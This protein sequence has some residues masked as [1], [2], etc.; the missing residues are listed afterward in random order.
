MLIVGLAV[1]ALVVAVVYFSK[2]FEGFANGTT[3]SLYTM[4]GCPHCEAFKPEWEKFTANLP[5]GVQANKIDAEDPKA[6]AAGIKGF[7]TIVI[8][9]DGKDSV[10]NGDRTAAAL[11]KAV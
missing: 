3:V 7:P 8:T 6:A 10:Y 2:R 5:S 4:K 11:T 1:V 9:K